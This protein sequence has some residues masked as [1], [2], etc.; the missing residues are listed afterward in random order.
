MYD[1]KSLHVTAPRSTVPTRTLHR[2]PGGVLDAIRIS[3]GTKV[4]LK[5]VRTDRDVPILE[6]L[7]SPKL[8]ADPRNH[9]VPL[10]A[11]IL[12]P[13]REDVMW[14]VMPLLLLA[15]D[16][17]HPFRYVSEVVEYTK[18]FLE[19]SNLCFSRKKMECQCHSCSQ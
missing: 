13:D 2:Q 7:N 16:Y 4:V 11:K 5:L 9:T 15:Q 14:I 17:K 1:G 8:L 3:D 6:D 18:Q 12:V 19:V 10:L